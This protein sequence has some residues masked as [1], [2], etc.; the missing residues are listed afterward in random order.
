M[1]SYR[2]RTDADLLQILPLILVDRAG[3]WFSGLG[4]RKR[5][6][7]N[8]GAAWK[9]KLRKAYRGPNHASTYRTML[10]KRTLAPN[11]FFVEY[12]DDRRALQRFVYGD[13]AAEKEYIQDMLSGIPVKFH[14]TIKAEIKAGDDIDDLRRIFIDQEPGLRPHMYREDNNS[15]STVAP[16]KNRTP[17]TPFKGA[18]TVTATRGNASQVTGNT[19]KSTRPPPAPC[20]C[21]G[22]HWR[23]DCPTKGQLN[24]FFK[25]NTGNPSQGQANKWKSNSAQSNTA[26]RGSA[27]VNVVRTRRSSPMVY[28]ESIAPEK[29][30]APDP[31]ACFDKVPT[32][33]KAH[34]MKT[35]TAMHDVCLDTGSSISLIDATY[36]RKFFPD[37]KVMSKSAIQLHGI[38][39]NLT[40][41]WVIMN[42]LIPTKAGH[43]KTLS[44]ALHVVT[45]LTT[46]IILGNDVLVL[47]KIQ[48]DMARSVAWFGNKRDIFDVSSVETTED[49]LTNKATAR[50]AEVYIIR[51]G[52]QARVPV[53]LR[54]LPETENY[55]LEPAQVHRNILVAHSVARPKSGQH[56]A[57][58]MNIGTGP[59]KIASGTL[60]GT[61]Q[62]PRMP[63]KKQK[64]KQVN[65]VRPESNMS[66]PE[67]DQL[68]E[69][70]KEMDI[71]P[72]L[73]TDQR[74]KMEELIIRQH[75]AF[76]YGFPQVGT[77]RHGNY[78][79]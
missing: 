38:G 27:T 29:V 55:Y 32:F 34:L 63:S 76:A 54:T 42:I 64:A 67:H 70:V 39:A 24:P 31:E 30:N 46:N 43:T 45:T 8:T 68:T 62:P 66:I 74:R 79:H 49:V 4:D 60:L 16:W 26:S 33:V 7:L 77:N 2:S 12:F 11:E 59:F 50:T 10:W 53:L 35:S 73:N 15:V 18:N 47:K 72:E 5:Q 44:V 28:E 19:V 69:A 1:F 52:H 9:A 3:I 48:L 20:V 13:D 14:P 57:Q 6:E 41:G 58:G 22:N 51:P 25:A 65:Y 23:S 40:Q 71:K 17:A 37:I 21:G 78:D 61:P 36:P 75:G 56:F